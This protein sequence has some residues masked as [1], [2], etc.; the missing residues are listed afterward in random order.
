MTDVFPSQLDQMKL[1][2]GAFPFLKN[3]LR[4]GFARLT[5]DK[6]RFACGGSCG[7]GAMAGAGG[8]RG[9]GTDAMSAE[10][11]VMEARS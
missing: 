10:Q 9:G 5:G 7:G 6:L 2:V 11:T 3:F 4:H 1:N 8:R